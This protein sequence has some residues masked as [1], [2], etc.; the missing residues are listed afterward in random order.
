MSEDQH[1]TIK[2]A[3][4]LKGKSRGWLQYYIDK[5]RAPKAEIVGGRTYFLR[6]VIE[7]WT[8][9]NLPRG[10]HPKKESSHVTHQ[11]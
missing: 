11:S 3:A 7:A 9:I 5:E 2:Q 4:S 8:P 6:E 1:L 10:P